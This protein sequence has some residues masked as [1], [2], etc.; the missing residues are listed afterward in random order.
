M[1]RLPTKQC[2]LFT[3]SGEIYKTVGTDLPGGPFY[4]EFIISPRLRY[5]IKF[6]ITVGELHRLR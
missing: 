1:W 6:T 5:N 3:F 4:V 2:F